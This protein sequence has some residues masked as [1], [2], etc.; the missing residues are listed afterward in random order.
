MYLFIY[1]FKFTNLRAE[2]VHPFDYLS[3][4][5]RACANS[6]LESSSSFTGHVFWATWWIRPW[7]VIGIYHAF[8]NQHG[9]IFGDLT[10]KH[11]GQWMFRAMKNW[12]FKDAF[13]MF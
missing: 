4:A 7:I 10:M 11:G 2:I 1:L 12:W 13:N 6:N 3:P 5:G 9:G 8:T